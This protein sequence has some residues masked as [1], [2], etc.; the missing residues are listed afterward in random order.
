LDD[1]KGTARRPPPADIGWAW[2]FD[3]DG[4]LIE[5]A[6]TPSSVVV[7]DD[8]PHIIS[9]L[10]ELSGGAVSLITGRAV[11]DV[12]SFLPLPGIAVAGQHGLEMR[13]AEG[14]VSV[15]KPP[16]A[17]FATIE[18]ELAGIAKRHH[19]LIVEHKGGSVAL[20]YRRAPQLAGYAHRVMRDIQSRHAPDLVIQK[21]KRVVEL[22]AR[23]TD[24]G[25]AI[26]TLMQ[27]PPFHGRVPAFVGDDVTDEAGFALVNEMGG[28][29]IKVG[30]GRTRARWRLSDVDDVREWLSEATGMR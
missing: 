16:R 24:K 8:L 19:G 2:F 26:N 17:D 3:I 11:S 28:H 18:S 25:V 29:S 10:H 5:I 15:D 27:L 7:H 22:R 14:E 6:A 21:G 12:E 13:S 23:G 30:S 20:H 9:R 4:T 1:K